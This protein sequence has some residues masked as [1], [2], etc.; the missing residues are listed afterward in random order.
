MRIILWLLWALGTL[1]IVFGWLL[2]QT[3]AK[4]HTLDV[5]IWFCALAFLAAA[6][7]ILVRRKRTVADPWLLVFIGAELLF[8]VYGLWSFF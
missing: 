4:D 3:P 8:C 5:D 6:F 1:T 7:L 2:A